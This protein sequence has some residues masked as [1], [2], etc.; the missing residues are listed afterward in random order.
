MRTCPRLRTHVDD[1][2]ALLLLH[3]GQNR[4]QE[5]KYTFYVRIDAP[6]KIF[7]RCF[8]QWSKRLRP[9]G[10]VYE[11]IDPTMFLHD[12]CNECTHLIGMTDVD[13]RDTFCLILLHR[14][15]FDAYPRTAQTFYKRTAET[16]APSRDDGDGR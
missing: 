2:P 6:I 7:L 8:F 4:V 14:T 3:D 15:S 12:I 11:N 9:A 5:M 16:A 10:I 1:R 13:R